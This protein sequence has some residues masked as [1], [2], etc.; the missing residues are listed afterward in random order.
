LGAAFVPVINGVTINVRE[1]IY[2][3]S[4]KVYG[5]GEHLIDDLVHR[6]RGLPSTVLLALRNSV[7]AKAR[8]TFT[9]I[10]LT[11]GGAAFIGV[12]SVRASALRT[13]A[14]A[15]DYRHYDL[16]VRL[17]RPY[18]QQA[19]EQIALSVPGVVKVESWGFNVTRRI[20]ADDTESSGIQ[21][22]AP[23]ADTQL[24][25]PTL[26]DGRWLLAGDAN[27]VVINSDVLRDE[28]DI[29]VGD[30][31]KLDINAQKK[32]YKVVGIVRSVLAGPYAY[33]N[34]PYYAAY[35]ARD[36][37]Q[38][39]LLALVLDDPSQQERVA[40]DLE[41]AFK[42]A[43]YD[44]GT[45]RTTGQATRSLASQFNIILV[46][47]F[48]M[49]ALV[50]VVSGMGLSGAMSMNVL[51]RTREIGVMRA[52][53]ASDMSVLMVFLIEGIFIGVVSWATGAVF[54]LPLSRVLSDSVGIALSRTPLLYS[55]PPEGLALWLVGSIL[56]AIVATYMPAH[57]AS[58]LS[59]REVLAYE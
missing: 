12:Y 56:L 48:I 21:V 44:V 31:I 57:R 39:S 10:T 11:L 32:N 5:F 24:L 7:R 40:Q 45:I 26:I 38:A 53:G 2:T 37:G 14:N 51:E 42:N 9:L 43:D 6:V 25:N 22:F 30:T 55:F 46:F 16:E 54:A 1:A 52:V 27:A 34:Y 33:I 4:S 18:R 41:A 35:A 50:A 19:I 29:K 17:S 59:V 49:A 15:Q 58:Q 20:R 36:A 23:P 28:P 13:L 47:L 8:L 3:Q